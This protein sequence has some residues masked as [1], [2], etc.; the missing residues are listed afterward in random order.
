MRLSL[1]LTRGLAL[2]LVATLVAAPA[3]AHVAPAVGD[4]NR[5][6]KL[7][8]L[9][10]RVRL[11]YT[12]FYGEIPGAGM[13]GEIDGNHDGAIDER[14]SQAFGTRLA[15]EVAAA[16]E[17]TV[18]GARQ[19]VAWSQVVV[20][21]GSPQTAAG[22]FSVDLVA[23]LCLTPPRGKHAV[24]LR[25]HFAIARPGETEVKVEDS[26]G[27]T[28]HTTRIGGASWED[29]DYKLVGPSG[30]LE[31]EGLDLEF[32]AGDKAAV[33]PDAACD[34][35]APRRALPTA[36]IV[37]AAAVTGFALAAAATLVLRIRRRRAR[38]R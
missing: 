17:V 32:T 15:G 25:D 35:A 21:M 10:D 34:G 33:T 5:Y 18:D 29:N 16:L 2:A 6:V 4:N 38:R 27:V 37:G 30:A 11:A 26:P 22:A 31:T 23:W 8:P 36:A 9:G 1:A 3:H 28:I 20:G 7:T 13:R 19:P 24:V 12:V 14:E